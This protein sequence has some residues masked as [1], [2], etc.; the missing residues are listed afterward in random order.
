MLSLLKDP[1]KVPVIPKARNPVAAGQLPW[2]APSDCASCR[3]DC[4]VECRDD[5]AGEQFETV[6]PPITVVPVVSG[7]DQGAEWADLFA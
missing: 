5:F 2:G 4:L 7:Q 1:S 6:S 3:T